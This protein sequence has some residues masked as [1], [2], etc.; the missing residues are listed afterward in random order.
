M[1]TKEE[2]SKIGLIITLCKDNDTLRKNWVLHKS[3]GIVN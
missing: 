1:F 2:E 3:Y